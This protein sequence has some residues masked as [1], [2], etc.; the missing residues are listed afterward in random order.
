MN[1]ILS[2]QIRIQCFKYLNIVLNKNITYLFYT[3][4]DNNN[5]YFT[6]IYVRLQTWFKIDLPTKIS[7]FNC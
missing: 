4:F 1:L 5:N 7:S 2:V 6:V 3:F